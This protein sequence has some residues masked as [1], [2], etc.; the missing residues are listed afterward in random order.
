MN[1]VEFMAGV[2]ATGRIHGLGI[3]ATLADAD[4]ALSVD[5]IDVIDEEYG[6]LRR[7]YGFVELYFSGAPGEWTMTGGAVELH[8]LMGDTH[9]MAEEWARHT[10]VVFPGSC[11]WEALREELGSLPEPPGL[12][13]LRQGGHL[14]YRAAGTKVSVLVVDDQ[15]EGCACCPR[16][17]DVWSVSLG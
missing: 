14:E 4:R 5:C 8:R 7:D 2:V 1:G 10:G 17:G 9:G 16:Y 13:L 6:T 12:E 3:G 15:E 11:T